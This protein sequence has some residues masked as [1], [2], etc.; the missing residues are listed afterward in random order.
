MLRIHQM[1][2]PYDGPDLDVVRIRFPNTAG[3]P[4]AGCEA[5]RVIYLFTSGEVTVCPY[6]VFAAKTPRSQH[7]P[8]EF[9]SATSSTTPTSPS[10]STCTAQP[11]VWRWA[12]IPCAGPAVSR[13]P[14][15]KAAQRR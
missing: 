11:N 12:P 14:A 8:A 1:I 3:K 5:G 4:L 15:G 9:M 6:L 13:T 2:D 10:A 7:D